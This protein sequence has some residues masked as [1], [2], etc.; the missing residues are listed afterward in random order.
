MKTL[1]VACL[2]TT[3]DGVAPPLIRRDGLPLRHHLLPA[4]DVLPIKTTARQECT[5]DLSSA[6][7]QDLLPLSG[8]VGLVEPTVQGHLQS[9]PV[10]GEGKTSPW[11]SRANIAR[12]AL[13]I[14]AATYGSNYACVKMLDEWVG[15]APVAA[16]LRFGV[17][18]AAMLPA[19][20]Y[21]SQQHSKYV[22]WPLARDGLVVGSWFFAVRS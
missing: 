15:S 9:V 10:E 19:L 14:V 18:C 2:L 12:G 13:A 21:L 17:A 20:C 6:P 16:T 3:V 7:Q 5:A 11:A 1:A 4:N 22:S 8:F